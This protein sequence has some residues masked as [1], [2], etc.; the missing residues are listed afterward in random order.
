MTHQRP[1]SALSGTNSS[2]S[3]FKSNLTGSQNQQP[4][5]KSVL[6]S[7]NLNQV[8]HMQQQSHTNQTSYQGNNNNMN[9]NVPSTSN[10]IRSTSMTN[11]DNRQMMGAPNGSNI[12]NNNTYGVQQ[13]QQ[14]QQSV[15][16]GLTPQNFILNV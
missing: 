9:T 5:L 15:K 12:G 16:G 6:N 2:T 14:L 10:I 8:S 13:Q 3:T 4:P 11:F 1:S 7:N